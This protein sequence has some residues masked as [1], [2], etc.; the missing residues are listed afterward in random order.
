MT[1][2]IDM[3]SVPPDQRAHPFHIFC[4]PKPNLV[5]K[6]NTSDF[7]R[8]ILRSQFLHVPYIDNGGPDLSRCVAELQAFFLNV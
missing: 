8:Y 2:M 5:P 7:T 1:D 3:S 6:Q 4:S